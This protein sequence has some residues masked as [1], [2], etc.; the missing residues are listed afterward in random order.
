M[1]TLY[2]TNQPSIYG[3]FVE[4]N[5][6]CYLLKSSYKVKLDAPGIVIKSLTIDNTTHN[7]CLSECNGCSVKNIDS[8]LN[9]YDQVCIVNATTPNAESQFDFDMMLSQLS[10]K[11]KISSV[12]R[13]WINDIN[14]VNS[15]GLIDTS[16]MN[17]NGDFKHISQ[18]HLLKMLI[19]YYW[20]NS[21]VTSRDD[22]KLT[23][24]H[25]YIL[26]LLVNHDNKIARD[27]QSTYFT[28]NASYD[29]LK[30]KI[31]HF[32]KFKFS[33][34]QNAKNSITQSSNFIVIKSKYKETSLAKPMLHTISSIVKSTAKIENIQQAL[35]TLYEKSFI[36]NPFS[37]NHTIPTSQVQNIIHNMVNYGNRYN[38]IISH[39]KSY[40]IPLD[41][42]EHS[43]IKNY[44]DDFT[45]DKDKSHAIL[46]IPS[47]RLLE[48]NEA[49]MYIY[50]LLV[51]RYF[52]MFLPNAIR[53]S[54]KIEAVS[55]DN[56]YL[57]LERS[58]DLT[59]GCSVFENTINKIFQENNTD[60]S[61]LQSLLP[62]G[63]IINGRMINFEIKGN[64]SS[65]QKEMNEKQLLNKL[66]NMGK[67]MIPRNMKLKY[68]N[69]SIG[70]AIS[71]RTY[72]EDLERMDIIIKTDDHT[73]TLSDCGRHFRNNSKAYLLNI[74]NL[75][76]WHV[77]TVKV[78]NGERA[79]AD[80]LSSHISMIRSLESTQNYHKTL[81]PNYKK[82]ISNRKCRCG[83][84]LKE[85]TNFIGCSSYPEC[86]IAI[87]KKIT[88]KS[89]YELTEHDIVE[90]IESGETST[91]IK[92]FEFKTGNKANIYLRLDESGKVT[93]KFINK[94]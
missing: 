71:W 8:E 70:D 14:D 62:I 6:N 41:Q 37:K 29:S 84:N 80:V 64:V 69:F 2:I 19:D 89:S 74:D 66:T 86:R 28:V 16:H 15:F 75:N 72:I 57:I 38:H 33:S 31:S 49:E 53:F 60:T 90:L 17:D 13:L 85:Y 56:T 24:Q 65:T 94:K 35:N 55:N 91:Q 9:K 1:N 12:K 36:T 21:K 43:I 10:N 46:P 27:V 26:A 18:F 83:K 73:F 58:G 25:Y 76:N 20:L 79:V 48:L 92:Q 82:I 7:I 47:S 22:I 54:K 78:L 3:L 40:G 67:N 81:T 45:C 23:L 63:S 50:D 30:G 5:L 42:L 44:V 59:L 51:L 61:S 39:V 4:K 52:T 32:K 77:D 11:G 88:S 68:R 87:S 34:L 93:Y